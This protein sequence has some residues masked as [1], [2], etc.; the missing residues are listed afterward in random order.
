[1]FTHIVLFKLKEPTTDNLKFVEN[2]LLSMNGEIKELKKLEV[3][4][5]TIRSDRSYDI[6]IITRFDNEEDYLAYDV[7]E[8]HVEKVK[9]VIGPYMEGSK[10]LDFQL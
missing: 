9:K 3:G 2:T 8:F 4:V 6:G 1:M 5:D 10:T 7:N